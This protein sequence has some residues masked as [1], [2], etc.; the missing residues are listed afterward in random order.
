MLY[1]IIIA[2]C[3]GRRAEHGNSL[4]AQNVEDINGKDGVI[5]SYCFCNCKMQC[6]GACRDSDC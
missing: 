1:R 6:T 3:C 4:W 2:V 5:Y